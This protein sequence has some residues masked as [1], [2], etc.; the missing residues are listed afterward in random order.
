M[1]DSIFGNMTS[2]VLG[3]NI[4]NYPNSE[5]NLLIDGLLVENVYCGVSI[6][7]EGEDACGS[8]IINNLTYRNSISPFYISAINFY[9]SLS[10]SLVQNV[11]NG[12]EF[13][14]QFFDDVN[15]LKYLKVNN[16][17]IDTINETDIAWKLCV[18]N[19]IADLNKVIIKNI[20][21]KCNCFATGLELCLINS[22]GYVKDSKFHNSTGYGIHLLPI[23]EIDF[24]NG[25]RLFVTR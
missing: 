5:S 18:V 15:V 25:H 12:V 16:F 8:I 3:Y 17:T 6:D 20:E 19:G 7:A 23:D 2:V 14:I 11:S 10:N 24:N 22:T 4:Y 1:I 13:Y 21:G 9:V